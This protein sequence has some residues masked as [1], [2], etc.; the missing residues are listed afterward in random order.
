MASHC[1]TFPSWKLCFS[2]RQCPCPSISSTQCLYMEENGI[3]ATSWPAHS[4]DKNNYRKYMAKT[5]KTLA[6]HQKLHQFSRT[7]DHGSNTILEKHTGK[8]YP[9]II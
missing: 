4:P 1:S 7:A 9:P 6:V 5:Q 3:N 8:L 2:R